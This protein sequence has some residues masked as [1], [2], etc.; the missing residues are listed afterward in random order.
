MFFSLSVDA[1]LVVILILFGLMQQW[2]WNLAI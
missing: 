2:P 1:V